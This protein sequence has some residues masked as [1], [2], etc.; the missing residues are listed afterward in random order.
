M[1]WLDFEQHKLVWMNFKKKKQLKISYSNQ[2]YI[3]YIYPHGNSVNV[4][5]ASELISYGFQN[6]IAVVYIQK[7]VCLLCPKS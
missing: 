4:T 2:I 7:I 1:G 5:D 3:L 6:S